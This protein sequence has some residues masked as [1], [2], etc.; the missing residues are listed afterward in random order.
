M[1]TFFRHVNTFFSTFL[2]K[3]V[4]SLIDDAVT[5]AQKKHAL[6][7]EAPKINYPPVSPDEVD[8]LSKNLKENWSL[9]RISKV[10]L[11]LIKIAIYEML[12]KNLP[13]KVA[14]NE[15]IN[16]KGERLGLSP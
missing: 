14:I 4:H 6:T 11:S 5:N 13:Y 15:K 3:K 9:D 8:M 2:F 10:N 7:D 1:Q 12:Y 16:E